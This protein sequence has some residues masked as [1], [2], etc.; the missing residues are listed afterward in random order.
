MN[1]IPA[2]TWT[3][4]SAWERDESALVKGAQVEP[5]AFSPIYDHYLV[6]VYRYLRARSDNDEDAEDL[7]QQVFLKALDALPRYRERGIPF[8]AWLFRIA[9]NVATDAH[10]RRKITV[11]WDFLPEA[12]HPN[13]RPGLEDVVLEHEDLDRLRVLLTSLKAD[14]CEILN[15]RFVAGLSAREIAVVVGKSEA[16]VHKRLRRTLR[17]LQ[18]KYDVG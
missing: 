9:R 11:S 13:Q 14:E 15:L 7:T 4:R 3:E 8:S 18:E 2:I 5:A 17:T 12:L 10:R 16:A 6:P 1:V